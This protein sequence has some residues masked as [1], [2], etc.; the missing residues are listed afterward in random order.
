MVEEKKSYAEICGRYNNVPQ[1]LIV[2][3]IKDAALE[4]PKS[5]CPK[6]KNFEMPI[7][8]AWI[9]PFTPKVGPDDTDNPKFN[10]YLRKHNLNFDKFSKRVQGLGK[11]TPYFPVIPIYAVKPLCAVVHSVYPPTTDKWNHFGLL[12]ITKGPLTN[13]IVSFQPN[14]TYIYEQNVGRVKDLSQILWAGEEVTDN[15]YEKLFH[16]GSSYEEVFFT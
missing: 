15:F 12:K 14:E 5:F 6:G 4:V 9:G 3:W 8:L 7:K 11:V 2:E 10:S 1:S 16:R 13:Q